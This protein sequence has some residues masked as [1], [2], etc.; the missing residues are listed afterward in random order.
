M[1][2]AASTGEGVKPSAPDPR[3]LVAID[4]GAESCRVSLLRWAADDHKPQIEMVHRFANSAVEREDGLHWDIEKIWAG[5]ELGLRRCAEIATERVAAIAVDGW[6]VD[7]VC[8]DAEDNLLWEPYCYRDARTVA[9]EQRLQERIT[10]ERLY[11]VTG[12]QQLRLNTLYQMYADRLAGLPQPAL[13]LNLPEYI[14]YRLGGRPVSEYTNAAHT[15]M[16]DIAAKDWSEEV[17]DAAGLELKAAPGIVP[18][19]STVGRVRGPLAQLTA[20]ED[21]LLIAPGCHD[22]ASAIAGIPANVTHSAA[23]RTGGSVAQ[24]AS[25][26]DWAYISS[27]TWSLVGTLLERACQG[28]S[29]REGNYTNLGAVGGG[30]CFH[31][32]VNGMWMLRQCIDHWYQHGSDLT[33]PEL[34][35]AAEKIAPPAGLLDLRDDALLLPGNMPGFINTQR[36][37]LGLEPLPEGGEHG[38]LYASLIFHSLA[39]RYAEVLREVASI[40]GKSFSR[41]YIVGGG[42]RNLLLNR[43]TEQATGLQVIAGAVE[44]STLGNFAVQMATLEGAY[45]AVTGVQASAVARWAGVLAEHA[46]HSAS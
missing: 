30:V 32:N 19:G 5:L 43:L 3:A 2:T 21:T 8:L 24:T 29:A 35:Q 12:I 28:D 40:T 23:L 16:V 38:P 13:W 27:G 45:D 46:A 10:P 17:F 7:Y 44:S 34:V 36:S 20:F 18:P 25:G 9:A 14:L 31:K 22:T 37:R 6:A 4:L 26:N 42:S 1:N 15:A 33:V 11:A 41:I 39:A